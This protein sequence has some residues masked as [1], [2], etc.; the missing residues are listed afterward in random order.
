MKKIIFTSIL[1]VISGC[2][3]IPK[4]GNVAGISEKNL[5]FPK[6]DQ[7]IYVVSEGLVHLKTSYKSGYRYKLKSTFKRSVQ[8]GMAS[9]TVDASESLV[10]SIL[11]EKEHHCAYSNA[12]RDMIGFG[13]RNVCFLEKDGLFT[14]LRYAPG[15]YWFTQEISP[16]LETIRTE[17]IV[18]TSGDYSKKE[19]IYNGSSNGTLM[20]TENVYMSDL[21]KPSKTKPIAVQI[22]VTPKTINISGSLIRVVEYTGN[23]LAFVLEKSF[24]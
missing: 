16:P 18:T 4:D 22:D 3:A 13:N 8:M 21:S 17:V 19:L 1:I 6:I 7:K 12:Y 2:T 11:D 9:I 20:F 15:A 5:T 24:D 23:T 14:E 10:P